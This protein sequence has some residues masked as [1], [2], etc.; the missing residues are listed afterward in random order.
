MIIVPTFVGRH[1]LIRNILA[2]EPFV[3]LARLSYMV[4]VIHGLVIQ[5]LTLD[6]RQ[7]FY[8]NSLNLWFISIGA[9]VVSFLFAIAG[10]LLF[11]APFM[12]IE[13]YLLFPQKNNSEQRI[14]A[15]NNSQFNTFRRKLEYTSLVDEEAKNDE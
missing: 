13:K 15:I 3:V 8:V 5:W 12:N 11:E 9:I 6:T 4:Y 14:P 10:T 7:A 1:R 2:S